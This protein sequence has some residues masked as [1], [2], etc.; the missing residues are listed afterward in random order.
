M[1]RTDN[2]F[3]LGVLESVTCFPEDCQDIVLRL[4]ESYGITAKELFTSFM[5]DLVSIDNREECFMIHKWFLY[6]FSGGRA[7]G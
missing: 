3:I 5:R 2:N 7:N 6:S 1:G 4:C